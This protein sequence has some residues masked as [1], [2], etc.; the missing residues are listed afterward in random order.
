MTKTKKL[1]DQIAKGPQTVEQIAEATGY[2]RKAVLYAL[3]A[4]RFSGDVKTAPE[5]H[6]LSAKGKAHREEISK[7]KETKS[8]FTGMVAQSIRTNA[9]SV[10]NLAG[11]MQ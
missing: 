9:N 8:K 1:L 4:M 2:P 5:L 3:R 11:A 7:P 6:T 10:F